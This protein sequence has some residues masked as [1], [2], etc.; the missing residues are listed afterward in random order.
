MGIGEAVSNGASEDVEDMTG[1]ELTKRFRD[2][3]PNE[4]LC[5]NENSHVHGSAYAPGMTFDVSQSCA[6][7]LP[8]L[9][10][11]LC[12]TKHECLT[13]VILS[14]EYTV[15]GCTFAGG[16]VYN[17]GLIETGQS[18]FTALNPSLSLL[19]PL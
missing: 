1:D 6:P 15:A 2:G 14:V 3:P 9:V 7:F 11:M 5:P 8:A 12:D 17:G 4:P 18:P 16:P 10:S 19:S 13:C